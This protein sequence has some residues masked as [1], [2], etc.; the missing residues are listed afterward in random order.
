MLS[1]CLHDGGQRSSAPTAA[2][3]SPTLQRSSAPTSQSDEVQNVCDGTH[4][5]TQGLAKDRAWRAMYWFLNKAQRENASEKINLGTGSECIRPSARSL[6]L[7]I[8]P[9]STTTPRRY[10]VGV[11]FGI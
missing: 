11:T 1:C 4:T 9:P 2:A 8:A 7:I 5:C 6:D 10:G 3:T